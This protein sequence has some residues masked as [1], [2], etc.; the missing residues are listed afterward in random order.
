MGDGMYKEM[1]GERSVA[2]DG[3]GSGSEA[4]GRLASAIEHGVSKN[5]W[6]MWYSSNSMYATRLRRESLWAVDKEKAEAAGNYRSTIVEA[7]T[8]EAL[9]Q[10]AAW[11]PQKEFADADPH[12]LIGMTVDVKGK[13]NGRGWVQDYGVKGHEIVREADGK[14]IYV[15]LNK[16]TKFTVLSQEYYDNYLFN[17][18]EDAMED[19]EVEYDNPDESGSES[20]SGSGSETETSGDE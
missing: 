7:T 17:A 1:M 12:D 15:T 13:G 4:E 9:Q 6:T 10:K 11:L 5:A 8:L 14:I 3:D 16:K 19:W 18:L 20:E 2:V